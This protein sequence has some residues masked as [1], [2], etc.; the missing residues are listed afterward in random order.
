MKRQKRIKRVRHEKGPL[1]QSEEAEVSAERRKQAAG[2]MLL[3]VI[4]EQSAVLQK[5]RGNEGPKFLV[6][7]N[8]LPEMFLFR[9]CN[10][11]AIYTRQ[12]A[13]LKVLMQYGRR[14]L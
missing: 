1:S 3:W 12:K 13:D 6:N 9:S 5:R 14:R 8:A 4:V 11:Q 2:H 10:A 7:Q